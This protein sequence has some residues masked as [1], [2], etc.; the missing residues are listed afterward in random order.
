MATTH[1]SMTV[2]A[3]AGSDEALAKTPPS[4]DENN[5]ED[6]ILNWDAA[7]ENPPPRPN[8][9]LQVKLERKGRSTP[10]P[11]DDPG[12]NERGRR[13]CNCRTPDL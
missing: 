5:V 10:I 13:N 11:V 4:Q 9:V 2:P 7:I 12:R 8:G 3:I 1:P 6:E